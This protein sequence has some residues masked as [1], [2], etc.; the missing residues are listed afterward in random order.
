MSLHSKGL[1]SWRSAAEYVL[2]AIWTFAPIYAFE[3]L[4]DFYYLTDNSAAFFSVSGWRLI[5]FIVFTLAGSVA[6]GALLRNFRAAV[7]VEVISLFGAMLAFNALCD[8]RVCFSTGPDGLEPLRLGLFLGC[9]AV[10]GSA[11]GVTLR[12]QSLSRLGRILTGFSGFAALGFYPVIFTFAGTSLLAP[13]HPW[14]AALMLGLGAGSIAVTTSLD[15]SPRLGFALP[16]I[17][18]MALFALSA[19]I[20]TA[21][22]S[23]IALDV[24]VIALIVGASA[25]AGALVVRARRH[26]ADLHRSWF[27]GIFGAC[28]IL[29]L[30][31]MLLLVPD[32]VA[33]SVPM[34]A[35]SSST[36]AIGVPVYAGAYMDAPP[37][38]ASGAEVT[39]SFAGTNVSSIQRDNFLSGGMGIHAAGCCVDGIDYSYRFD[40]YLFHNGN[41]TLVASAW[42]ICDD[43]AACGGHSWKVQMFLQSRPLQQGLLR[44]NVSLRMVWVQNQTAVKVLWTYQ[45]SGGAYTNFTSF[46]P[47]PAENHDFN[48]GVL[49]GGTLSPIQS[50]SYFFQFGVMSQYPIGHGGWAI[51]LTCPGVLEAGWSCVPHARTITGSQSFWKVFWR[52]GE[53]YSDVA[54]LSTG[55][56]R[57]LFEYSSAATEN[58]R[59]LW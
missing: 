34:P 47:P 30:L 48:T 31:M 14:A 29:V 53:D 7:S 49:V 15:L 50:G 39:V 18:L 13:F 56:D 57:I 17:S 54:A 59:S 1:V 23:A 24:A 33:G 20:A 41:E 19:G 5:L 32:A 38:H 21:Y 6:A 55:S 2:P 43:N 45:V 44:D 46:A 51:T 42:E 11:L 9:I 22:F 35:G 8:P 28:L 10:S 16:M 58:F 27:S 4:A 52:W 26:F 3:K 36:F 25:A 40:I 12:R 37:G